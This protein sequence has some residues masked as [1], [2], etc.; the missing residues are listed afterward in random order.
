MESRFREPFTNKSCRRCARNLPKRASAQEGKRPS[1][2][3][4]E[5]LHQCIQLVDTTGRRWAAM[6]GS[7][8]ATATDVKTVLSFLEMFEDLLLERVDVRRQRSS[9]TSCYNPTGWIT[10]TCTFLERVSTNRSTRC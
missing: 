4:V 6:P 2:C 1:V 3:Q 9:P 5:R 7:P 10:I 8:A